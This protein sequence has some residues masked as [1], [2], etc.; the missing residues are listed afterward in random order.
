ML[1]R[2]LFFAVCLGAALLGPGP[3]RAAE[4]PMMAAYRAYTAALQ[5]GDLNEAERHAAL[6]LSAAEESAS[7]KRGILAINLATVRLDLGRRS[8]AIAPANR[9]AELLIEGDSG[10]APELVE[11]VQGRAQLDTAQRKSVDRLIKA[12][13]KA[14]NAGIDS[15]VIYDSAF[16]FGPVLVNLKRHRDALEVLEI[17]RADPANDIDKISSLLYTAVSYVYLDQ[18]KKGIALIDEAMMLAVPYLPRER[19]VWTPADFLFS[20]LRAWRA[21][22]LNTLLDDERR[23]LSSFELPNFPMPDPGLCPLRVIAEPLPKY[24]K[25]QVDIGSIGSLVVGFDAAED[26][27]ISDV[28]VL[29]SAPQVGDFSQAVLKVAS[30]WRAERAKDAPV[31]CKLARNKTDILISFQA[32]E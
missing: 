29:A 28:V 4:S 30:S 2:V 21:V 32:Y 3:A 26:G 19:T 9:A 23:R 24:P 17:A 20:Q 5:S 15:G 18:G 6:A 8:D 7:N 22:T 12:I 16:E 14:Q 13:K 11:L 27:T 1:R 31:D 25:S 10:L